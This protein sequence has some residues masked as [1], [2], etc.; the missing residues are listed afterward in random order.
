M[1]RCSWSRGG[2]EPQNNHLPWALALFT[3]I[4]TFEFSE[5]LGSEVINLILWTRKQNFKRLSKP[6]TITLQ[7]HAGTF[8]AHAIIQPRLPCRFLLRVSGLA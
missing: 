4:Y 5:T 6:L 3:Q 1:F 8:S 7:V 2:T